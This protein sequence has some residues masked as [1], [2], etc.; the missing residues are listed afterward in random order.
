M[1]FLFPPFP[2]GMLSPLGSGNPLQIE[3]MPLLIARLAFRSPCLP[4]TSQLD[5]SHQLRDLLPDLDRILPRRS[6]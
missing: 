6:R 2:A 3:L 5:F 1:H 4:L